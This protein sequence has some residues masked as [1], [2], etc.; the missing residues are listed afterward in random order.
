MR[1]HVVIASICLSVVGCGPS[2][3]HI[4]PISVNATQYQSLSCD[5][6]AGEAQRIAR[7]AA[8]MAGAPRGSTE[9]GAKVIVWPTM[10]FAKNSDEVTSALGRLKGTFDALVVTAKQKSCELE[11]QQGSDQP[12][13]EAAS[14]A[15]P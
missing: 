6:I 1:A 12:Q 4:E 2:A 5:E 7:S 8:A 3:N 9:A 14:A 11:F 13:D 10:A 15:P